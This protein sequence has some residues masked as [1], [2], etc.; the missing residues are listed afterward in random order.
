MN[1]PDEH[2]PAASDLNPG[3]EIRPK[4][5]AGVDAPIMD[6][7]VVLALVAAE[8]RMFRY[9]AYSITRCYEAVQNIMTD[10]RIRIMERDR[11]QRFRDKN[12]IRAYVLTIVRNLAYDWCDRQKFR[13][14]VVCSADPYNHPD[15]QQCEPTT[16]ISGSIGASD[17]I[18]IFLEALWPH[19]ESLTDRKAE[20]FKLRIH[21]YSFKDIAAHL[22]IRPATAK[23]HFHNAVGELKQLNLSGDCHD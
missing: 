23:K 1:L 11:G 4:E 2:P 21:G 7:A 22:G 17:R 19:L 16:P 13:K 10:T 15:V 9:I 8:E 5:H 6:L 18:T 3:V 14:N 20:V 12:H